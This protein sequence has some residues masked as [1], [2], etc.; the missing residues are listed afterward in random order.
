[1]H[2]K[3]TFGY[4]KKVNNCTAI[5]T[6]TSDTEAQKVVNKTAHFL[7]DIK[8]KNRIKKVNIINKKNPYK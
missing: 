8:K 6:L 2:T 7:S 1:M 3:S 5:F 4:A